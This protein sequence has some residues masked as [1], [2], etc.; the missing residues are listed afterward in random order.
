[1]LRY[2]IKL[3]YYNNRYPKSEAE[4]S[5]KSSRTSPQDSSRL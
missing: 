1:M 5:V 4:F 2:E 3:L